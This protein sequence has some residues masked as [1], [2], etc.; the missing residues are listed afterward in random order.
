MGDIIITFL[1]V[2]DGNV[3]FF[4]LG[5]GNV[6]YVL[7]NGYEMINQGPGSFLPSSRNGS[8]Y[9]LFELFIQ[10]KH[11]QLLCLDSRS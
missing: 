8:V 3:T 10:I 2:D 7:K 11:L 5:R 6:V 4:E 9:L 1:A